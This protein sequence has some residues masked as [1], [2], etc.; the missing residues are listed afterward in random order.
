MS[1][2]DA[3]TAL[4]RDLA[5][6]Q[7]QKANLTEREDHLKAALRAVAGVGTTKVGDLTLSISQA[8]KLEPDTVTR[9]YEPAEYPEFYPPTLD[10]KR[11]KAYLAPA[12]YDALMVPNGEPRV[13]L[14]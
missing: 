4:V 9:T 10:T 14:R 11:L 2:P 12:D 7:A 6:V 3:I 1:T 8:R 5:E 13:I